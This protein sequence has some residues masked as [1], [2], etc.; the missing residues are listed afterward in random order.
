MRYPSHRSNIN[1]LGVKKSTRTF[2]YNTQSNSN[3]KLAINHTNV[4]KH[5]LKLEYSVLIFASGRL[6]RF[7][8]S[9]LN[10]V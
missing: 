3:L 2:I 10:S 8:P 4:F 6:H 9:Q 1:M 5:I 7:C